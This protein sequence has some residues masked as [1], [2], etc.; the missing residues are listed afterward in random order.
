VTVHSHSLPQ[1]Y[2]APPRWRRYLLIG[3][4]V[5]VVGALAVLWTWITIVQADPT[6]SSQKIASEVVDDHTATAVIRV[7]WGDDPVDAKCTVRAIA[8]DKVVVGQH[9]FVPDPDAGPD[10]EVVI[11][12]ERRA[13][14]VENIGCTAEGQPR[15][16]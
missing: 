14:A 7:K 11:A 6:V 4:V 13:T 15:P 1:R 8:T 9:T 16:R 2:G 12:T 3:L 5:V 10:Y